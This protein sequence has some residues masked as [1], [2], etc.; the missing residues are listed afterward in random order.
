MHHHIN[1]KIT[2]EMIQYKISCLCFVCQ[3]VSAYVTLLTC[4]SLKMQEKTEKLSSDLGPLAAFT[5]DLNG[6]DLLTR[7][8]D[9][10]VDG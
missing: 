1:D 8:V 9:G 3:T 10:V 6:G 4:Y 5:N 2:R 7:T